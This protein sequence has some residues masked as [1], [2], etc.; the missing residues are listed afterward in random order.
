MKSKLTK[1]QVSRL[2]KQELERGFLNLQI[3]FFLVII[4]VIYF[5][6]V[7][8]PVGLILSLFI[9]IALYLEFKRITTRLKEL[10]TKYEGID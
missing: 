8:N 6:F 7:F 4:Q 2:V 10:K 9:G 5:I 3:L 1:L